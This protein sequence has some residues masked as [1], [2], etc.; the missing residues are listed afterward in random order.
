MS[1]YAGQVT[2]IQENL[3]KMYDRHN[4]DGFNVNVK[5]IDGFQGGEQ[6]VIILSTVRTNNRASLEF[7]ASLQRTNV[8]LTRARHCLWILGNERALTSNENVWR[9]IVLDAKSRKCFFNVDRDNEMT[10]AILD[11]MKESDQFDDLLDT[12][13]VHFKN[14]FWKICGSW[15]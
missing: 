13:S 8:A 3:G 9:A 11:A 5:S 6:D 15:T 10:K 1:P 4:H 12:N 14:A 7:I 2:A